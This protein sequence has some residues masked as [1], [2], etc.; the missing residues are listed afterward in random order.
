MSD[1]L[2][3]TCYRRKRLSVTCSSFRGSSITQF[4][5]CST[6]AATIATAHIPILFMAKVFFIIM[7]NSIFSSLYSVFNFFYVN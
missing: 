4:R 5:I 6:A 7:Q 2:A 1:D 3:V